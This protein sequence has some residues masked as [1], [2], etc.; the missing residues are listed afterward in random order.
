[1]TQH[2]YNVYDTNSDYEA[3]LSQIISIEHVQSHAASHTRP[4]DTNYNRRV[5]QQNVVAI[6]ARVLLTASAMSC[7]RSRNPTELR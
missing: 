3:R 7:G 6:Y 1:M 5:S 4:T 2:Q